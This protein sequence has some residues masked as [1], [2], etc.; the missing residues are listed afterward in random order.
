MC[1][2]AYAVQNLACSALFL[3]LPAGPCVE[4]EGYHKTE[5][6]HNI[7]LHVNGCAEFVAQEPR[8]DD[9]EGREKFCAGCADVRESEVEQQMVK[10]GLVRIEWGSAAR[11]P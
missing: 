7:Q 1:P 9:E 8:S 5:D 10:M 4:S 2:F 3:L 11:Y 6:Y